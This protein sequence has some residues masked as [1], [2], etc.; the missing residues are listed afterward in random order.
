MIANNK[1]IVAGYIPQ[2]KSK[3]NSI[4]KAILLAALLCI[5]FAAVFSAA[6]FAP[7]TDPIL[8]GGS[9]DIGTADAGTVNTS[10][11]N[12][13]GASITAGGTGTGGNYPISITVPMGYIPTVS[14][15]QN[16]G[17]HSTI[18]TGAVALRGALYYHFPNTTSL[19]VV[20]TLTYVGTTTITFDAIGQG[21]MRAKQGYDYQY[22]GADTV[23]WLTSSTVTSGSYTVT[24][25]SAVRVYFYPNGYENNNYNY[26]LVSTWQ[27][28]SSSSVTQHPNASL[29][30]Q[31][32]LRNGLVGMNV[33][34]Y[35][36]GVTYNGGQDSIGDGPLYLR[37]N[38]GAYPVDI[39]A[40]V[41]NG[42]SGHGG[43]S[44]SSSSY[45]L[46]N[47]YGG[48][49]L[50]QQPGNVIKFYFTPDSGY[51]VSAL[52]I[53]GTAFSGTALNTVKSNNYYDY[54]VTL[55]SS[56]NHNI[57]VTFDTIPMV[58]IAA[59]ATNGSI[60]P[61]GN[62]QITSG[63]GQKFDF[64]PTDSSKY[65]L[66]AIKIGTTNYT[67]GTVFNNAKANGSYTFSNV[68]ANTSITVT[69]ARVAYAITINQVTGGTITAGGNTLSYTAYTGDSVSISAAVAA[70]DGYDS[71]YLSVDGVN[72]GTSYTI[73]NVREAH[74]ITAVYTLKSYNITSSATSG[75]ISPSGTTSVQHGNDQKFTFT[76]TDPSKY[77]LT[78]IR[79]GTTDYTSGA[80]FNNA[81]ANG[82]YTFSNVTAANN[83]A[84]TFARVA[85]T[86]TI[87][88]VTGGTITAGGKTVSYTAYTGDS[89]AISVALASSHNLTNILVDGA[90]ATTGSS[91]TI[92]NIR[93][94]YTITATYAIKKYQ[95]T[96]SVVNGH[97]AISPSAVQNVDHDATPTF[98]FTPDSTYK[99]KAV[100]I[101]GTPLS[102][103]ALTNAI[104]S[105]SYTFAAV[106]SA[107]T[108]S[109]EFELATFTV[110]TSLNGNGTGY[111]TITD[112]TTVNAYADFTVYFSVISVAYEI[113]GISINGTPLSGLTLSNTISA[114][115]YE[116]TNITEA[117]SIV[118]TINIK[119]FK[120]TTTVATG[121][122]GTIDP[123]NP[124]VNYDD[125]KSFTFIP[126]TGREVTQVEIDGT[127]YAASNG[128][129]TSAM[130]AGYTFED[131]KAT[132]SIIVTFSKIK[133]TV[134]IETHGGGT[135]G[136]ITINSVLITEDP[137]QP[138]TVEYGDVI[139]VYIEPN[140]SL[141]L[142][143]IRLSGT[144]IG[145]EALG[146]V[147]GEYSLSITSD[148]DIT[149]H[150]TLNEYRIN[151]SVKNGV[152]GSIT[153][154]T[155]VTHG[156]SLSIAFTPSEGYQIKGIT[157]N[158]TALSDAPES[159]PK[160]SSA[161]LGLSYSSVTKDYTI[162]VEYEVITFAVTASVDNAANGSAQVTAP[163]DP[164][165][166]PYGTGATVLVSPVAGQKIK[167]IKV[168]G[169]TLTLDGSLTETLFSAVSS[170]NTI[171]VS[172]IKASINVAIEFE[173]IKY[174]IS[175]SLSG[176]Y[177]GTIITST[178]ATLIYGD[179]KTITVTLA[180]G[181][182][183]IGAK[184]D[185][186]TLD[187]LSTP[188]YNEVK[189]GTYTF[190]NITGNH[191]IEFILQAITYTVTASV[192]G[193]NGSVPTAPVT[194]D[195]NGSTTITI[196]PDTA[197]KI[198][199][200]TINGT[201]INLATGT[202][203][204][205][206]DAT[207]TG[208]SLSIVDILENLSVVVTFEIQTFDIDVTI[209]GNG[210]VADGV[211]T[212]LTASGTFTYDYGS[213]VTIVGTPLSGLKIT[214]LVV[215]G[216]IN[217]T[218][219][220]PEAPAS[221]LFNSITANHTVEVEFEAIIYTVT[222]SAT[223][224]D[225]SKGSVTP[226]SQDVAFGDN[227]TI[228]IVP[229]DGYRILSITVNGVT[230]STS[231]G[232]TGQDLTDA[233]A[234]SAYVFAPTENSD[235]EVTFEYVGF[236]D[237][238]IL[239]NNNELFATHTVTKY[240]NPRIYYA[241]ESFKITAVN[242]DGNIVPP[243]ATYYDFVEIA[244]DTTISIAANW[245]TFELTVSSND[246]AN[247]CSIYSKRYRYGST[248]TIAIPSLSGLQLTSVTID[249]IDINLFSSDKVTLTLTDDA[250]GDK[251]LVISNFRKDSI[252]SIIYEDKLNK[253]SSSGTLNGHVS[254]EELYVT[255]NTD[256]TI[257]IVP[258]VGYRL[259]SVTINGSD[260]RDVYYAN[261]VEIANGY[262]LRLTAVKAD[263][264][265]VVTF[266]AITFEITATVSSGLGTISASETVLYGSDKTILFAPNAGYIVAGIT[267]DNIA[268]SA[269]E[270]AVAIASGYTFNY[271]TA[272]HDI[273]VEFVQTIKTFTMTVLAGIGGTFTALT[274][275][276]V[277]SGGTVEILITPA[278]G[279]IFGGVVVTGGNYSNLVEHADGTYTLVFNNV[280]KDY[281]LTI[282]FVSALL[283]DAKS[284]K[285][286]ANDNELDGKLG[287]LIDN[288]ENGTDPIEAL[289]DY[290]TYL[291]SNLTN[292]YDSLKAQGGNVALDA[293][294]EAAIAAIDAATNFTEATNAYKS[295]HANLTN[296]VADGDSALTDAML[297]AAIAA[298]VVGT[299]GLASLGFGIAF[300]KKK[301]SEADK[302]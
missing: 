85:Y 167:A 206:F 165:A 137:S 216:T 160:L 35:G 90:V 91:Y 116:F 148:V 166:V 21:S 174:T 257:L 48:T 272:D 50:S 125:N 58:T 168:N 115:S 51:Q 107:Q 94:N 99:V 68:T 204:T 69:F 196:T 236:V 139:K 178:D 164:T 71:Y 188:T 218:I 75:T 25:H 76:P 235:V 118:V 151:T 14:V 243:T 39:S 81:K 211:N 4:V 120:I 34:S 190:E 293:Q 41:T 183:I 87:N 195:Y 256:A 65:E 285:S 141:H 209:I 249:G 159:D 176:V 108:I 129:L 70:A 230:T 227:A 95:I 96:P 77:E 255:Y 105:N 289:G 92:S 290:G 258:D 10:I 274:P 162:V 156:D 134:S 287:E 29:K 233:R 131:V 239:I 110:T 245:A 150:F 60:S 136:D 28:T 146:D 292:L 241:H 33:D 59:S 268:L 277:A 37:A 267:V 294:Y 175:T 80:V 61:S 284:A 7:P 152:G 63:S 18:S 223:G 286:S 182:E 104:S 197:Y 38:F 101:N 83:I 74:T 205:N 273:S 113:T 275:L 240:S 281:S 88:Q 106:T 22:S 3:R 119:T 145:P 122:A 13:S 15:A 109:V 142:S 226:T 155:T 103:T 224:V 89:S 250:N 67:S 173:N 49:L 291:K 19:D 11:T 43:I 252:V 153:P 140:E 231:Q 232:I 31:L 111:G 201:P 299:L 212:A 46:T 237:I 214:S 228:S 12:V 26:Y 2:L 117:K 242:I 269:G 266:E 198:A 185:G 132:H 184:I 262:E 297:A 130:K 265:V 27:G 192:S 24:K 6:W 260:W 186:A 199:S 54:S 9:A 128:T 278:S 181:F 135:Y 200:I 193:L 5:L 170:A 247:L 300:K 276:T 8:G 42:S 143:D 248:I 279:Y 78:K 259:T 66:T 246:P 238:T 229:D 23:P 210:S 213:T 157:I 154:S 261:L 30:G 149:L 208:N 189:G 215:D 100:N 203:E 221:Y 187:G 57:T 301:K 222:A 225:A 53:D 158:E 56:S 180:A 133:Y 270:I 97:G 102:S 253:I 36:Y 244:A 86:I 40:S 283:A 62:T 191:S 52:N 271:I 144:S 171:T 73:T 17:E 219:V 169:Y 98:N 72:R 123:A 112:T 202:D 16:G 55:Y 79:I 121:E 217:V 127:I 251:T 47:K 44:T 126:S 177:G 288:M 296:T 220:N 32:G 172:D 264:Y 298:G 161:K 280:K 282:E 1:N 20:V 254:P 163:A 194:V 295:N 147:D 114:G 179:D 45:T 93:K 124:Y 82:Y 64:S 84:V 234:N 138:F 207:L 263:S 302:A